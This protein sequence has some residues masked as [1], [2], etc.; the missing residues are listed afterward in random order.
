[1]GKYI[2]LIA[3]AVIIVAW[4]I[5]DLTAR[6]EWS[7]RGDCEAS[8]F[9]ARC[10]RCGHTEIRLSELNAPRICPGCKRKMR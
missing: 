6:W 3:I 5:W 7:L 4:I 8:W 2:V 10:N 1:M 9:E